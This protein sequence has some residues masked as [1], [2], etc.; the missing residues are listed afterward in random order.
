MVI[1]LST[2]VEEEYVALKIKDN[3]LGIDLEK[4][5]KMLFQMYKT[6]HN[7]EDSIGLG[8]FITKNHIESLGGKVIVESRVD[9]GTEFTIYFKKGLRVD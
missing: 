1:E 7:K 9:V 8:L 5:G 2:E 4:Y 6:F 3:G